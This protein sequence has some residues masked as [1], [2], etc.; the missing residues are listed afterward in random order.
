MRDRSEAGSGVVRVNSSEIAGNCSTLMR[1]RWSPR[2]ACLGSRFR[3]TPNITCNH[4]FRVGDHGIA[5]S[6]LDAGGG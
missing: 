6:V 1:V 5:A 3:W 2:D 4:V